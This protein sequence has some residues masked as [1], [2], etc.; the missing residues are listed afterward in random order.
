MKAVITAIL[1]DPEARAGDDPSAAV[2]ATFGHLREPVLFMAN[3]LRGLN[4]TLTATS[5]H[6][7][8]CHQHGRE[9]V[10][11]PSVFSYFSPQNRGPGSARLPNFRSTRRRPRRIAR[12]WSTP[13]SYGALDKG[14]KVNLTPFIGEAGEHRESARL[15]QLHFPASQH[16][17]RIDAGRPPMRSTRRP[18]PR[19]RR[20]RRSIRALTS[21][22]YQ[23]IQ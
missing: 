10:Q 11:P 7:H 23:I 21:G 19:P 22:E 3:M 16:V 14:T 2:S 9:P 6:R 4:A 1:T 17:A 15:H 13:R 12:T 20:R 5:R 18:L 8:R